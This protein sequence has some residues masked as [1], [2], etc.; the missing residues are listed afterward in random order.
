MPAGFQEMPKS[1]KR[2]HRLW[3]SA[4]QFKISRKGQSSLCRSIQGAMFYVVIEELIPEMSEGE[5]SNIGTL[6]FMV[7]F[8]LMMILDVALG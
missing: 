1:Q 7:G 6:M 5:H 2:R 8:S 4:L 3:H